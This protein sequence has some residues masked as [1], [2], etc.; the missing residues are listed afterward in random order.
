LPAEAPARVSDRRNGANCTQVAR[1]STYDGAQQQIV[2]RFFDHVSQ[3]AG[4]G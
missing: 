1:D 4:V 2:V 3:R